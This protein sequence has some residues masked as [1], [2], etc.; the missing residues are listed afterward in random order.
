MLGPKGV[1]L[2]GDVT[3]LKEVWG[4]AFKVS[5]AQAPPSAEETSCRQPAEGSLLLLSL[6]KDVELSDPPAPCLPGGFDASTL[7]ILY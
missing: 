7:M 3:L 1:V 5:Y 4:W 6:G 2:L